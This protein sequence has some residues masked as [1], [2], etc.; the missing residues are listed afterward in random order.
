M[1]L[2]IQARALK[3][4]LFYDLLINERTHIIVFFYGWRFFRLN[5][6]NKVIYLYWFKLRLRNNHNHSWQSKDSLCVRYVK[7][8]NVAKHLCHLYVLK[9]LSYFLLFFFFF[10]IAKVPHNY[11]IISITTTDWLVFLFQLNETL[12]SL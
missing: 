1:K 7:S 9:K 4:F 10:I 8:K 5:Y 2:S 12:L 3:Q 11:I 6:K